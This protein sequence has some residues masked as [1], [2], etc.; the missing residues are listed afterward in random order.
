M[1][2]IVLPD[3]TL[4]KRIARD[5]ERA[6]RIIFDRYKERFYAA[7]WKMTRS[8]DMSEEIVQEVFLSL[9]LHRSVLSDV[10]NPASYLFQVV[11]N[12]IAAHFK[13]L[14]VQKAL[15]AKAYGKWPDSGNYTE[16]KVLE[17]ESYQILHQ[18]IRQLPFQQQLIYKLSKQDG[19]SRNEIA[20]RLHIS[21]NTVKN[22]LLKAMKFIKAQWGEALLIAI[23]LFL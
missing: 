18:I 23:I 5:D 3:K 12:T 2:K 17:K 8:S 21:P 15:K 11:C 19:L 7:A 22:H 6:F 13:R 16:E 1:D 10:E 4:L 20:E 9:W 14:A